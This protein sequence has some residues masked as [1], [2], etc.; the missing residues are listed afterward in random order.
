M[1][2]RHVNDPIS[3]FLSLEQFSTPQFSLVFLASSPRIGV[4]AKTRR[5]DLGSLYHFMNHFHLSATKMLSSINPQYRNFGA[6]LCLHVTG[7]KKSRPA[8][9]ERADRALICD[10]NPIKLVRLVGYVQIDEQLYLRWL[11]NNFHSVWLNE[12]QQTRH[13]VLT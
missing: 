11:P 7:G 6:H 2:H 9:V 8:L 5:L 12:F 13:L 4:L 3:A 10:S 1:A